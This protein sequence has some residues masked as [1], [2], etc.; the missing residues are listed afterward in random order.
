MSTKRIKFLSRKKILQKDIRVRLEVNG[1]SKRFT[2]TVH[3]DAYGFPG[4]AR[5]WIEAKQLLET[6]RFDLGTV[7][8]PKPA[9]L[10]D[11]SRLRGDRVTFNLLVLDPVSSRK[12]GSAETIRPN[13]DAG[14]GEDSIPL[15]PVDASLRL[16]PLLW[17]IEYCDNDQ[18]GHSDAPVL[19]F[20][21]G[22]AQGSASLFVQDPAVRALVFPAAM[23]EVLTRLLLVDRVDYEPDSRSWRNS[24][25][26]FAA[27][28]AGEEPPVP[29]SP[30]FMEEAYD[31]IGQATSKHAKEATFLETYLRERRA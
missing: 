14:A 6:L 19:M 27:R 8:Q 18:E 23:R 11:V 2:A 4:D 1:L 12:L 7:A 28:L 24:W 3:L 10:V 31:W 22:A 16:D 25:L 21:S 13:V 20:D 29:D 26:R 30:N 17:R 9:S 5:I 15:L